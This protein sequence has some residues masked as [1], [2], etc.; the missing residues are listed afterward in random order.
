MKRE[1]SPDISTVERLL[2][3]ASQQAIG[4]SPRLVLAINEAIRAAAFERHHVA[5]EP[6]DAK[7]SQPSV[8]SSSNTLPSIGD[9]T[10]RLNELKRLQVLERTN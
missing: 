1:T 8:S 9:L 4:A 3:Q 2:N 5:P 10:N 7:I 6:C